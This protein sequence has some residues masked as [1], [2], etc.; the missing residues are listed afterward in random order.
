M[1][2]LSEVTYLLTSVTS[3]RDRTFLNIYINSVI[4]MTTK[5]FAFFLIVSSV[6]V[7]VGSSVN[8]FIYSCEQKSDKC[9]FCSSQAGAPS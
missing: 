8:I 1:G 7:H 4:C 9:C 5:C 3:V 6:G 2:F